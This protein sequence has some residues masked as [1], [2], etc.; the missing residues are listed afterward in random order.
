MDNDAAHHAV[1]AMHMHLTGDYVTLVDQG[2]D[3]L[4][5]PHLH[6]WLAAFS[7]KL[8]GVNAFAYK[9]PSFLFAIIGVYSTFRL[10]AIL[11][12][13][14]I[15]RLAALLL[16]TTFGFMLSVSD[17]RMDAILTSCIAF[18]SWQLVSLINENRWSNAVGAAL[19]LALGFSTKGHIAVFVPAILAL[20]HMIWKGEMRSLFSLKW[21]SLVLLFFLFISP[22]LYCYYLQFN[23]HPE[24]IVR[25]RDH[26]NGLRFILFDQVFER[27]SGKM[28]K[29]TN[30]DPFFFFH[31]ILPA[32]APWSIL[33]YIAVVDRIR[34]IRN[35]NQEYS[36]LA[37]FLVIL[38]FVTL[39]KYQLPHYLNIIFPST[40]VLLAAFIVHHQ[41]SAKWTKVFLVI[42]MVITLIILLAAALIN[43]WAFPAKDPLVI[44][45]VVLLLAVVFYFIK[46]KQ[47]H[48]LQKAIAIPASAMIFFFFLMNI[49]FY[50]KLLDYQGGRKLASLTLK[51]TSIKESIFFW[52][53]TYSSSFNF[54]SRTFRRPFHDSLL[55]KNEKIWI[56]YDEREEK[57]ILQKYK[58][59][60]K[61]LYAD[62]FEVTRLTLKFLDPQTR[63][64]E[65]TRLVLAE[66][67][68]SVLD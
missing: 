62:D 34:R 64:N 22:V 2:R 65:C 36:T 48:T 68:N 28:E 6:F 17:V 53:N 45:A 25:G 42:Q 63:K 52:D 21:L 5:K 27:M 14:E 12:H 11:Y 4:D 51:E 9:L 23:L 49:N 40:V 26:I 41:F 29:E 18:A 19:G 16:A 38:L 15:G 32:F 39:S 13:K 3:Y 66:I 55:Q 10:G 37:V 47:Y 58:L 20:F 31:S 30:R 1:I 50:P 44:G 54:H 57:N 67:K 7:Y 24:K 61:K 43:A 56:L 60:D 59:G 33:V 46:S 35:T 8:F